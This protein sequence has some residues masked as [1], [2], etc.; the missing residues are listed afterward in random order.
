[1]ESDSSHSS[2]TPPIALDQIKDWE[3]A[4]IMQVLRRNNNVQRTENRRLRQ[5]QVRMQIETLTDEDWVKVEQSMRKKSGQW[6]KELLRRN[7]IS[8]EQN[9]NTTQSLYKQLNYELTESRRDS[10]GQLSPTSSQ[11]SSSRSPRSSPSNKRDS[12]EAWL[13]DADRFN[14]EFKPIQQG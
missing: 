4:V 3:K 8:E 2:T 10:L 7:S 6:Y 11:A 14:R 9:L 13:K 12:I 5:L 1:M